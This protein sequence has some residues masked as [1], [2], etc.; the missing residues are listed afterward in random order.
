LKISATIITLN[1]ESN[2]ESACKSLDWAD[3]IVVVDSGSSDR[4]REIARAAGAQ[5]FHRDWTGFADQKQFASEQTVND[6]VFSL[7]ADEVVSDE[8]RNEI[9]ALKELE[10]SAFDCYRVP[11]RSFYMGRWIRFSG[12]YPDLQL[13]LF[14]KSKARWMGEFVHES[15]QPDG[16]ARLG[17]LR[18]DILHYSVADI[19]EHHRMI[20][21]RYAPLS[22][23]K[24]FHS[25]KRTSLFGIAIAGPAAFIRSFLLKQGFRDGVAGVAIAGF[26]AHNSFLKHL[27]L[28]ELQNKSED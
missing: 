10:T 28:Y 4:T 2:I 12:W 11:R 20:G 15:V 9:L 7:D 8:L 6:W 17:T 1:E 16:T 21:E 3:E 5:V 14:R 18:N 25:G 23:K 27:M 26:A 24:M 19:N 22:A 13:R